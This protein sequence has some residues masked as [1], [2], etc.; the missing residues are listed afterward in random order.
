MLSTKEPALL[1]PVMSAAL[2]LDPL[3]IGPLERQRRERA[4]MSSSSIAG[5]GESGADHVSMVMSILQKEDGSVR[6][7]SVW[8]GAR[9]KVLSLEPQ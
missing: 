9:I 6:T 5:W 2:A 8:D 7:K 3:F 1:H 4:S